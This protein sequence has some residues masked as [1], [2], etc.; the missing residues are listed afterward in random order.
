MRALDGPIGAPVDRHAI[1]NMHATVFVRE[2]KKPR[3][4]WSRLK[5]ALTSAEVIQ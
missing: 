4:Q 3:I 1:M 5:S 2:A